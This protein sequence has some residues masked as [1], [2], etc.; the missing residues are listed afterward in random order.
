MRNLRTKSKKVLSIVLALLMVVSTIFVCDMQ[1]K[2]DE[3]ILE[4]LVVT[5]DAK[6][7]SFEIG[8]TDFTFTDKFITWAIEEYMDC[9]WTAQD[10]TTKEDIHHSIRDYK[11][12]YTL[13][14][15]DEYVLHYVFASA[16]E[17][18]YFSKDLTVS[19]NMFKVTEHPQVIDASGTNTSY[20]EQIYSIDIYLGTGAEIVEVIQNANSESES[21]EPSESESQEPSESESQETR[22]SES[23]EPSE[24][25]SQEPSESESEEPSEE[26]NDHSAK[27]ESD[28]ASKVELTED[29]KNAIANGDK[30]EVVLGFK[31]AGATATTDEQKAIEKDLGDKKLGTFLD[32]DLTKKIGTTEVAVS[33]TTGLVTITFELPANL[34]NTDEKVTR[35]YSVMRYHDGKVDTLNAKYDADKGTISFETDKFSTYAVVYSD[36]TTTPGMG[37]AS[38]MFLV[39][40]VLG[41]GLIVVASRKKARI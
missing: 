9:Y 11:D 31:D 16:K 41:A 22:E 33:E 39:Y 35:T 29:E 7:L 4:E 28:V 17:G 18:T 12:G 5:F 20:G 8:A 38:A 10:P 32:I 25:E 34:K 3:T 14:E 15:T 26:E 40:L 1:A 19:S 23:Q 36:V 30:L 37:D 6:E 27:L 2:A 13:N 21:Q 24:S